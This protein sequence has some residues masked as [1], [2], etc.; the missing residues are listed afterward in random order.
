MKEFSKDKLLKREEWII[1]GDNF[2]V[3][4]THV[5]R[6]GYPEEGIMPEHC[7][8]LYATIFSKHRL[9]EKACENKTDYDI[10]L[11][12]KLYGS[13]HCGCTYYNRQSDYVKIGCDYQHLGDEYYARCS[14]LPNDIISDAED[15]FNYLK[16]LEND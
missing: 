14:D 3:S 1:R 2:S 6:R 13:F 7:W 11:G 8:C 10:D 16:E 15:L 12:D 9:F 5:F 4:I